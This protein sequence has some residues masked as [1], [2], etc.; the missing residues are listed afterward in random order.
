MSQEKFNNKNKIEARSTEEFKI[1]I[2]IE[3]EVMKRSNLE[4]LEWTQH[5]ADDFGK[6]FDSNKE[7]FLKLYKENPEEL[8]ALIRAILEIEDGD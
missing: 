8:Y 4:H 5:Y 1:Y 7:N 6:V 2:A 3:T